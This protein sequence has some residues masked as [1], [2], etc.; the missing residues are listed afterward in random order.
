MAR[1]ICTS[2]KRVYGWPN[3]RGYT[4]AGFPCPWCG[5]KGR[6]GTNE[7]MNRVADGIYYGSSKP[8][9]TICNENMATWIPAAHNAR[10][11][12]HTDAIRGDPDTPFGQHTLL[13]PHSSG[14][15]SIYKILPEELT[16]RIKGA[17]ISQWLVIILVIAPVALIL[18]FNDRVKG[19][20][21]NA[22]MV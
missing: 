19:D 3:K 15:R 13:D 6:R 22:G 20:K 14:H 17:T 18:W 8:E 2:C 1:A 12:H 4:L 5:A 16:M 9:G 21:G 11:R 7:E 10:A